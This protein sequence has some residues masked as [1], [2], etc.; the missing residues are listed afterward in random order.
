MA[1]HRHLRDPGRIWMRSIYDA[2]QLYWKKKLHY[3]KYFL[4]INIK[5]FSWSLYIKPHKQAFMGKII[6]INWA[7]NCVKYIFCRKYVKYPAESYR[8]RAARK[9]WINI[10]SYDW[11]VI[12][13]LWNGLI[14]I[15]ICMHQI[16][17][18]S[19][20]SAF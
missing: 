19:D 6:N 3:N 20:L 18:F 14:K 16:S 5:Y 1:T 7:S 2:G 17:I 8:A 15:L 12:V 9:I 4:K 13:K 10:I 11:L